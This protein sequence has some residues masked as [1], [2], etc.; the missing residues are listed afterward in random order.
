MP[1]VSNE[2]PDPPFDEFCNPSLM[3]SAEV[4]CE[5]S[6]NDSKVKVMKGSNRKAHR[7]VKIKISTP[8]S[9]GAGSVLRRLRTSK[10]AG[11]ARDRAEGSPGDNRGGKRVS[12]PMN[13]EIN[14]V[15]TDLNSGKLNSNL[16]FSLGCS[17][18][19]VTSGC[20]LNNEVVANN[21][22][23]GNDGSFIKVPLDTSP[24]SDRQSSPVAKSCG[25]KTSLD[26]TGMETFSGI[27]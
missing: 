23:N 5:A 15:L 2:P 6:L 1:F 21:V 17:S 20:S 11:K 27:Y 14:E 22:S 4:S 12:T 19:D 26:N 10:V 8:G 3:T 7:G 9:A 16:K 24:C 18:N 13:N 25:L